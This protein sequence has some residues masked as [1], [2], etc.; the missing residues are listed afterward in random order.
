MNKLTS[1]GQNK[2]SV[3]TRTQSA[4]AVEV[5]IVGQEFDA[6]DPVDNGA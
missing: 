1:G 5:A 2:N 3:S 6:Q 4:S